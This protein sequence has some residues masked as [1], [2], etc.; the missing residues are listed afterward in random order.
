[1]KS[2]TVSVCVHGETS[3]SEKQ[4]LGR[5]EILRNVIKGIIDFSWKGIDCII[6]PGGFFHFPKYIGGCRD[7][8]R[9]E[10][11][12]KANF[13]IACIQACAE[14]KQLNPRMLIIAGVDSVS[15]KQHG[16]D[17]FC[18]AWNSVGIAGIGRKIFPTKGEGTSY[19]CYADDF[20]THNRIVK[21]PSGRTAVL[22]ACYDLFGIPE[23]LSTPSK[24]T[25]NIRNIHDEQK[26]LR[27]STSGDFK[28]LRKKCIIRWSKLL[29]ENNVDTGITAIHGFRK[30]GLD[31]FWQRHGIA[32]AS[33]ALENGLGIGAAHF[34]EHLPS[35]TKSTLT[36]FCVEKNHLTSGTNRKTHR[37]PPNN[38]F[39]IDNA[40]VRLFVT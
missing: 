2:K 10:K 21:L 31:G 35:V 8:D 18:V 33:S 14:L 28:R 15:Q 11:I 6:F 26:L 22:C 16:H 34:E 24:R 12:S 32:T 39:F 25:T 20:A 19:I 27:F 29:R 7:T 3:K 13:S 37:Q 36:S 40:V 4:N 17:Q 5:I 23:T 30:P 1:M 38:S 9:S